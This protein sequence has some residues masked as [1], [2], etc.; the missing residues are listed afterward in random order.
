MCV[1]HLC[2]HGEAAPGEPDELRE[3]TATGVDQARALGE[4]LAASPDPPVVVLT[5]PLVRARQTAAIVAELTGAELRVEP[6]LAPGATVDDLRRA[7]GDLTGVVAT[8]GHQ[9]DCSEIAIAVTGR[10]PGFSPGGSARLEL[11]SD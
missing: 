6:L 9:P 7:V 10:D 3:L 8:V 4:H 2:R 11:S 5:S 1:V